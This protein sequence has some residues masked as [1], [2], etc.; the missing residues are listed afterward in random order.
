MAT[1][2][3]ANGPRRPASQR[4]DRGQMAFTSF[5]ISFNP[6]KGKDEAWMLHDFGL[7]DATGNVIRH[8]TSS[9]PGLSLGYS[10]PSQRAGATAFTEFIMGTLWPDETAWRLKVEV[11]R[12]IG[13]DPGEVVTFSNV[14]VP[15]AGTNSL[16]HLTNT[17]GGVQVVLSAFE[18]QPHML[19]AYDI[20]VNS[21]NDIVV[22]TPGNP[23][24][25]AVDILEVT[26]DGG[27]NVL[28]NLYGAGGSYTLDMMDFPANATNLDI[29]LVVQKTRT[30]EF[31][32]K[33]PSGGTN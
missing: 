14:P 22:E 29:R 28:G 18:R 9:L 11:K 23:P 5:R 25:V 17:A 27:K 6:A 26:T 10:R 2:S 8:G 21:S 33:P 13:Y 24:G 1:A 19:W 30:V 32:V 20:P 16:L 31:Y 7:E 12:A 3:L 4:G 15:A